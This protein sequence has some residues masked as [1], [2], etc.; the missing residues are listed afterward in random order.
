MTTTTTTLDPHCVGFRGQVYDFMGEPDKVYCFY[1]S[2]TIFENLYLSEWMYKK[3]YISKIGLCVLKNKIE[4][5]LTKKGD[6]LYC[7]FNGKEMNRE[8]FDEIAYFPTG[9]F[10][11]NDKEIEGYLVCDK[12]NKW[13]SV[14]CGSINLHYWWGD[15]LYEN[16]ICPH[17]NESLTVTEIG[18]LSQGVLPHGVVGCTARYDKEPDL[19]FGLSPQGRGIIEGH[20]TDY[21]VSGLFETDFKYNKFGAEPD[22]EALFGIGTDNVA[23]SE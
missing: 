11:Q 2:K 14:K 3:T 23:I 6:S 1:S 12:D 9:I 20:Y 4:V 16:V 13:C 21:E 10:D 19:M 7:L 15:M 17:L 22:T 18:I 8:G 5:G